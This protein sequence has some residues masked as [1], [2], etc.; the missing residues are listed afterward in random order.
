MKMLKE[1]KHT[2]VTAMRK[3]GQRDHKFE[4]T[5]KQNAFCILPVHVACYESKSYVDFLRD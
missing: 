4:A 2:A 1:N 3:L 5:M